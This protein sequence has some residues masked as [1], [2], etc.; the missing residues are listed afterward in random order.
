MKPSETIEVVRRA[1]SELAAE[2]L[3]RAQIEARQAAHVSALLRDAAARC[4]FHAHRL[5]GHDL[6]AAG[7]LSELPVMSKEDLVGSFDEITT[8]RR[9]R[10]ASVERHAA[11]MSDEDPLLFGE[12]RVLATGGTTGMTAYLPFDRSSWLSVLAPSLRVAQTH[13]F[14]PRFPPRRR[15]ATVTAGGPL[16]MT[17]RTATSSRSSLYRFL[18]L[19]VTTPV[20]ELAR[21][22]GEF[23]PDVLSGY[24]SVLAALA[25]EQHAGRL[26][27]SPRWVMCSSEQLRASARRAIRD[28]W[29]DPFD[30]YATTETGGPL[31]FECTAHQGLHIREETCLVE[32]VDEEDR[33]VPDGEHAAALL[34]TSWLNRTLPLI[35]YRIEDPVLITS[36]PCPCGRASK[37]ILRLSGRQEETLELPGLDGARIAIHPN[38]FQETIEERPEVARY[39]VLHT[40]QQITVSVVARNDHDSHWASELATALTTRLHTLGADP[41]PI[42]VTLVE[43]LE[44]PATP[45]AKLKV[46]RSEANRLAN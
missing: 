38:H 12:Y 8:D 46:I 24:P 5:R 16:H 30:I 11:S 21:A 31:A 15:V 2:R 14:G 9:L 32:A 18:R 25:E 36:E 42:T 6:Q 4:P 22:L 34:V 35:R 33:L 40:P 20:S 44:R 28:A 43:E 45:G 10:S 26:D 1:R 3:A 23:R 27:I 13:G 17:H 41:P 19:D 29:V 39:Q 7:V 37:R